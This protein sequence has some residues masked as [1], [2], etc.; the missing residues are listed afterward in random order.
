MMTIV[1]P[2][3]FGLTSLVFAA[4]CVVFCIKFLLNHIGRGFTISTTRLLSQN[5]LG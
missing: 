4:G 3:S 2:K 5:S 1:Q